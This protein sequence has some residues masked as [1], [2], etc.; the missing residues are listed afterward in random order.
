MAPSLVEF[1]FPLL[2]LVCHRMIN[3]LLGHMN[4]KG[5]TSFDKIP[6]NP[7]AMSALINLINSGEISG[8]P[9]TLETPQVLLSHLSL[10][11]QCQEGSRARL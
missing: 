4:E 10:S 2:I 5:L 7:K 3:E 8:S 6:V 11:S 1:L 9:P